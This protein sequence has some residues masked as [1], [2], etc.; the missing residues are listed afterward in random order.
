MWVK[1]I[2]WYEIE[3]QS[4]LS[5]WHDRN[6]LFCI[7]HLYTLSCCITNVNPAKWICKWSPKWWFNPTV[8]V[9]GWC[10]GS[11]HVCEINFLCYLK[12]DSMSNIEWLDRIFHALTGKCVF[13]QM[14]WVCAWIIHGMRNGSRALGWR[15]VCDAVGGLV[16]TR[17]T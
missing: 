6:I 17:L 13:G 5:D 4:L 12:S 14:L 15:A 11:Q 2:T 10:C 16:S 9:P 8:S 1:A 7:L 3:G